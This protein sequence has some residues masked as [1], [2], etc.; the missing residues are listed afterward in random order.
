MSTQ[1]PSNTSFRFRRLR[2]LILEDDENVAELLVQAVK[3]TSGEAT[4]APTIAHAKALVAQ[5]DFDVAVLDHGLPDGNGGAFFSWL[6]EQGVLAPCLMLTGSPDLQ[7]AIELTR[8]GLFEYLAKPL[9]LAQLLGCLQRAAAH[10]VAIQSSLDGF[11]LVDCS[12]AM[13]AVRRRVQQAAANPRAPVLLTG[14]TGVGK[15]LVARLIHQLTFQKADAAPPFISLNCSTLPTEMFE[16]ELFG[17]M[18]GAYTGAHQNRT[19]LAEAAQGG[20][21]FLDEIGE[22]PLFLQAKLLQFLETREFRRLGDTATLHFN[23]RIIAATNRL[24]QTEVE[25]GRFRADLLYRLDVLNILIPPLRE[26]R[27]DV[28]ALIEFQLDAL[29]RKYERSRPLPNPDDLAV[30]RAYDYPGNVR[31]L[32]NILERS[33]LQTP[34]DAHW[35]ELDRS[36]QRRSVVPVSSQ[37][38]AQVP[39]PARPSARDLSPIEEQEYTLIGRTLVHE[40]GHIRRSAAKLDMSHQALLRRLDKWPELRV[41]SAKPATARGDEKCP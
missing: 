27:E 35:L 20:T 30:L 24:L 9:A 38:H 22:V 29:S 36:W 40:R 37:V 18:K 3:T 15:D 41:G 6:R 34:A 26:R 32:R 10:S 28:P 25:A 16:A 12:R 17:A 8:H 1:D 19:G 39:L 7:T 11:G 4:V 31:E 14:E 23:G 33:M 13:R 21:L 2:C 5:Q